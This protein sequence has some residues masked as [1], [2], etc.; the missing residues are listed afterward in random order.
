MRYYKK[1]TA[2]YKYGAITSFG[3]GMPGLLAAAEEQL[4]LD[5]LCIHEHEFQSYADYT[6]AIEPL[7]HFNEDMASEAIQYIATFYYTKG[8]R[9]SVKIKQGL[10]Q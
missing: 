10:F 9:D 2:Q 8:L 6:D 4:V 5:G 7:L 1:S 3:G